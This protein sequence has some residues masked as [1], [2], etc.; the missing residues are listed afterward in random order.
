MVPHPLFNTTKI[1]NPDFVKVIFSRSV[2]LSSEKIKLF[3]IKLIPEIKYSNED[4]TSIK[5]NNSFII[6]TKLLALK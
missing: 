5:F 6:K 3:N 4:K 2:G 1:R